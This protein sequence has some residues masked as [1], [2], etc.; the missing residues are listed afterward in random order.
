VQ[1]L[2]NDLDTQSLVQA[3]NTW[4]NQTIAGGTGGDTKS[5][6][7]VLDALLGIRV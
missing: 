5:L 3:V 2:A 7:A 4:V 6:I 1:S